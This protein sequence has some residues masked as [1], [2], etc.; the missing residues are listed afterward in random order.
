MIEVNPELTEAARVAASFH[1]A[2]AILRCRAFGSGNINRTYLVEPEAA[3]AFLLQS[4]NTRV[5]RAPEL[6]SANIRAV[7]GHLGQRLASGMPAGVSRW[8]LP[9]VLPTGDGVDHVRGEDGAWWRAQRF[10]PGTMTVDLVKDAAV[11]REVGRGLGAFHALVA[12]LPV[13][14]LA[15]TL[16]GFH[17]TPGY[18]A[19]FDA[20][21]AEAPDG[22]DD[23]DVRRCL[24]IVEA[25][26]AW[27]G[28]LEDA[29][30]AGRLAPRTIHGDPKVNNILLDSRTGEAV[31][32]IDLDTVKP[33]LLHYDLGDCLRSSCNPAGEEPEDLDA[34]AFDLDLARAVLE[35]YMAAAGTVLG[36]DD[37]ELIPGSARLL[38]FELGLRFLTDH[39]EGDT[40]FRVGHRGQ[41]LR[42]AMVQFRLAEQAAARHDTLAGIVRSL[43]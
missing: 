21:V 36:P 25:N 11:A 12:D 32:M 40:Y 15:D 2:G 43:A 41:N 31:A 18:L 22:A 20:V 38:P 5:F 9:H 34:V 4:L 33:G 8:E 19:R 28:M 13:G 42:R 29:L 35:G 24:A 27:A 1:P 26:R 16:P 30:A 6:V 39:L 14:D 17:V 7:L 23:P 10:I 3:P 37:L